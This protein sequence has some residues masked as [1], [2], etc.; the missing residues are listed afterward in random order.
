M[1]I[2]SGG[3]TQ[4]QNAGSFPVRFLCVFQMCQTTILM[5]NDG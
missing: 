5:V 1:V 3:F 4:L 2:L